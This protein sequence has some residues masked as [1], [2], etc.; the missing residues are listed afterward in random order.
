M[1]NLSRA[2]YSLLIGFS[3]AILMLAGVI[4]FNFFQL[5]GLLPASI[6]LALYIFSFLFLYYVKH[7]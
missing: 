4:L 3:F 5:Y 1:K 6:I 2:T 7:D